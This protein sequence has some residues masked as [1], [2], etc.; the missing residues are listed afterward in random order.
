MKIVYK[1]SKVLFLL[2]N[3]S[4]RSF[5]LLLFMLAVIRYEKNELSDG[6]VTNSFDVQFHYL[7]LFVEWKSENDD[8]S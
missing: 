7:D 4:L 5:E 1:S 3:T 8:T 2:R 6:V